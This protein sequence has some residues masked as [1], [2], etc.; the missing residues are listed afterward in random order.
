MSKINS[1]LQK[2]SAINAQDP[3]SFSSTKNTQVIDLR[4]KVTAEDNQYLII[5]DI[6]SIDN[7]CIFNTINGITFK[8]TTNGADVCRFKYHV[9]PQS[10]KYKGTNKTIA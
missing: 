4:Q 2:K 8:V 3:L 1:N 10:S 9:K 6:E 7:R 5:E